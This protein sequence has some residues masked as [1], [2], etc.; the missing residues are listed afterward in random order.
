MRRK[1]KEALEILKNVERWNRDGLFNGT[2]PA[3]ILHDVKHNI[4]PQVLQNQR[5]YTDNQIAASVAS[6]A[7]L[8]YSTIP[9]SQSRITMKFIR[10]IFN[11]VVFFNR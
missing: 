5:G 1:P 7:N 3:A 6:A 11:W 8:K 2:Y 4:L 10:K 9:I